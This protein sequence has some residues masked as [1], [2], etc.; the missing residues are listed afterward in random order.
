MKVRS[1]VVQ[2]YVDTRHA[3]DGPA[4]I[5]DRLAAGAT[6]LTADFPIFLEQYVIR[7]NTYKDNSQI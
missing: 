5:L 4:D 1:G 7:T 3:T 2:T 6:G